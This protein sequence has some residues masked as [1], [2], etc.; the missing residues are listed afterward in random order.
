M[1]NTIS[2]EYIIDEDTGEIL[3]VPEYPKYRCNPAQE[4]IDFMLEKIQE[5]DASIDSVGKRRKVINANLDKKEKNLKRVRSFY[6]SNI[7]NDMQTFAQDEL[8][9]SK[10]RS[11]NLDHGKIGYRKQP[12]SIQINDEQ[13][14]KKWLEDNCKD[15][16]KS[17]TKILVSKI[18][19]ELELPKE[20]IQRVEGEDKFYI[21]TGI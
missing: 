2:R 12:A 18:P 21:D 10:S 16:L 8:K 5:L 9:D 14:A 7:L 20:L 11:I 3:T 1:S 4:H 17:S 6:V 13:G 19:A 15:A